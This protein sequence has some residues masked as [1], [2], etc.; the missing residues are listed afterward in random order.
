MKESNP[1]AL[2]RETTSEQRSALV[3]SE[4]GSEGEE[5]GAAD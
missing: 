1:K 2:E 3:K 5:E 4:A